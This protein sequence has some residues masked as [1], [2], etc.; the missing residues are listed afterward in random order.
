[1]GATYTY[2]PR[3]LRD[4]FS[5]LVGD[6]SDN[7]ASEATLDIDQVSFK[8]ET[9][10]ELIKRLEAEDVSTT[11]RATKYP[12]VALI[13]NYD[14]K[15]RAD[16]S[17]ADVSLTLV[18]VTPSEPTK[19]SEDRETDNYVPILRP[20]YAELMEVIKDSS[21]FRG[22]Y[23]K[24]PTHTRIESFHLGTDSAQGNK[25]YLLP[26]CVDGI[27]IDGLE[28]SLSEQSCSATVIGPDTEVVY[29]NNVS[30]LNIT[31]TQGSFT[32]T[33]VSAGYTDTL[34]VGFGASPTYT[35]YTHH[36]AASRSIT[37][38]QAIAYG[39]I[40]TEMTGEYYGYISCD[41][42]FRESKLYFM[43]YLSGDAVTKV[44]NVTS[45]SKFV[46]SDFTITGEQY[47]DYPFDV[48]TRHQ[49][50]PGALL[51]FQNLAFD[52]GNA[53][54]EWSYAPLT[55]DTTS[56]R[57]TVSEPLNAGYRDV[58]NDVSVSAQNFTNISYY[59]QV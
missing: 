42:G 43:Y 45:Q 20:I 58:T 44:R 39:D 29:L 11:H 30:E 34:A 33:L 37:V 56:V 55:R 10:I 36:T 3:S 16:S 18:I 15:Y 48:T 17:L 57:T 50:N 52:G 49:T 32:V 13:R 41:D 40:T 5:E 6:V 9:W 12:L 8:C 28:L 54:T 25:A 2:L 26:D 38:G 31:T 23:M 22:Y 46:L 27:I 7:L 53:I 47:D 35:I 59:K 51:S 1:M 24:Y 4:I 19:L 14:E 21:Y